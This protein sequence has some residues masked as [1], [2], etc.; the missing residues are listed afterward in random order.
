MNMPERSV[1][2]KEFMDA[3]AIQ[4]ITSVCDGQKSH[5]ITAQISSKLMTTKREFDASSTP[6]YATGASAINTFNFD[7]NNQLRG[8]KKREKQTES[9]V[10]W[11]CGKHH[12]RAT[13]VTDP[14]Q[15]SRLGHSQH[16]VNAG[17]HLK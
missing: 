16:V 10:P 3:N 8:K 1:S 6:K 13:T 14:A 17:R 15:F 9:F 4:Q 11:Q 2:R 7:A 12:L 5:Q